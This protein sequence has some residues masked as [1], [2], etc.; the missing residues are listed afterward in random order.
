[1]CD[2]CVIERVKDRMLSRRTLLGA[3]A[4][5]ALAGAAGPG[6]ARAQAAAAPQGRWGLEAVA[7]LESLPAAGATLVV[8]APKHAGG[9]GGPARVLALV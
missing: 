7:N 3:G 8:G 1:M 9:S 5:L 6:P 4:T 2:A